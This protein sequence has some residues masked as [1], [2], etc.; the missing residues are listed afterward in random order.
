MRRRSGRTTTTIRDASHP[1][2]PR[3]PAPRLP[4]A[5]QRRRRSP[6]MGGRAHA[7]DVPRGPRVGRAVRRAGVGV[8][9]KRS[10]CRERARGSVCTSRSLAA[11]S[12]RWERG[13]SSSRWIR[14]ATSGGTRRWDT[15]PTYRTAASRAGTL[16]DD[17]TAGRRA[18]VH[19][20]PWAAAAWRWRRAAARRPLA[21]VPPAAADRLQD[22][23]TRIAR[24][25]VDARRRGDAWDRRHDRRGGLRRF[26]RAVKTCR[27]SQPAAD[28]MLTVCLIKAAS[29]QMRSNP[30]IVD[31]LTVC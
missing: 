20:L 4:R 22:G 30:R 7:D 8:P 25:R 1:S 31:Q 28:V 9:A 24:G 18:L 16:R 17:A 6:S 27:E 5:R 21:V 26:T 19:E 13:S 3:R 29:R 11:A 2:R 14:R 12:R 15:W 10:R 23:G